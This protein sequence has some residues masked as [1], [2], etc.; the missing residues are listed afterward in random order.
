MRDLFE[1]AEFV[2]CSWRLA[3]QDRTFNVRSDIL[4][5]VIYDL[6]TELPHSESLTFGNTRTGMCCYEL[7]TIVYAMQAN[8]LIELDVSGS[9]ARVIIDEPTGRL[10]LTRR[11]VDLQRAVSFAKAMADT[12]TALELKASA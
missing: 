10:L 6:R 3:N 7:E 2:A 4:S 5:A 12:I 9:K 11:N 8:L 1:I